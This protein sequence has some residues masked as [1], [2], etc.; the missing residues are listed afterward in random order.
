MRRT[1]RPLARELLFLVLASAVPS[2]SVA[3]ALAASAYDLG[4][5]NALTLLMGGTALAVGIYVSCLIARDLRKA[6]EDLAADARMLSRATP[7]A[8][9]EPAVRELADI[10]EALEA[11]S[12]RLRPAQPPRLDLAHGAQSWSRAVEELHRS[13]AAEP[14]EAADAAAWCEPTALVANLAA[15]FSERARAA[16]IAL[17][18]EAA[19]AL[20]AVRGSARDIEAAL[21]DLLDA[22]LT[23]TSRDG[24]LS[25]LAKS[26][27]VG[28]ARIVLEASR[29]PGGIAGAGLMVELSCGATL[30]ASLAR[31]RQLVE[32]SGGVL[33]PGAGTV[34][35]MLAPAAAVRRAA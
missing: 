28:G 2:A 6:L 22:A 30:A 34:T 25:L 21:A 16:G 33:V 7:I 1:S 12:A 5:R 15:K 23:V 29:E 3:A 11:A 13:A 24:R 32:A 8:R 35:I 9:L 17:E 18:V 20:G 19:S 31:A 26:T 4:W 10:A 27:P 14:R